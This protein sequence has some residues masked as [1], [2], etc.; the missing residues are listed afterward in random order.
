MNGC[1]QSRVI[2]PMFAWKSMKQPYCMPRPANCPKC[3][4][5][6]PADLKC[7]SCM[8]SSVDVRLPNTVPAPKPDVR[9]KKP[10][11]KLIKK[12]V[13]L[14]L[15]CPIAPINPYQFC[16]RQCFKRRIAERILGAHGAALLR[17]PSVVCPFGSSQH[18]SLCNLHHRLRKENQTW[19]RSRRPI[20]SPSAIIK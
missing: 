3:R 15:L 2:A 12:I 20:R 19:R 7:T 8:I 5:R 17:N 11:L 16:C 9:P 4:L 6:L 14:K 13:L 10:P 18:Y 1:R